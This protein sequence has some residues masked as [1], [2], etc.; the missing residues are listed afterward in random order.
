MFIPSVVSLR[1]EAAIKKLMPSSEDRIRRLMAGLVDYQGCMDL[2]TAIKAFRSDNDKQIEK[3]KLIHDLAVQQLE[4]TKKRRQTLFEFGTLA[5]RASG[6]KAQRESEELDLTGPNNTPRE[7]ERQLRQKQLWDDCAVWVDVDTMPAKLDDGDLAEQSLHK[8][9]AA[10]ISKGYSEEVLKVSSFASL[11]EQ[12]L[13]LSAKTADLKM[14]GVDPHSQSEAV[15]FIREL[16]LFGHG[17]A[18]RA[19]SADDAGQQPSFWVFGI[20]H[21]TDVLDL[22]FMSEKIGDDFTAESS[23]GLL[24]RYMV[25]GGSIVFRGCEVGKGDFGKLFLALV[26]HWCFGPDKWGYLKANQKNVFPQA[27]A[28][29]EGP[30]YRSPVTYKWPDDLSALASKMLP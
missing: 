30:P 2:I 3:A 23:L 16:H 22:T 29:E 4:L 9:A 21:P 19:P 13:D 12:L 17:I 14:Y 24:R 28:F 8:V 1:A 7:R 15:G 5:L 10:R 27:T 11:A 6:E 18:G 25:P 20:K 26:G